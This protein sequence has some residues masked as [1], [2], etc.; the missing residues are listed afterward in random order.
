M[1]KR[2]LIITLSVVLA[3]VIALFA[4]VTVYKR[5]N[6]QKGEKDI[7]VTVTF[8]DES[9]KVYEINTDAEY[10][11]DALLEEK[12][13]DSKSKD[14][15]YTVIAGEEADY[16]ADGRWWSL[17]KDGKMTDTGLNDTPIKDGDSFE[18]TNTKA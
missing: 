14:G 3:V 4:G 2:G 6:T 13:I 11:A 12:V 15:M 7:K 8:L 9:Q 17:T 16:N 5:L 10:L 1:K 18:I